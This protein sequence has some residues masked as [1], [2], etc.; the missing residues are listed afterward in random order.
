MSGRKQ[1]RECVLERWN[2][3]DW[4]PVKRR[5]IAFETHGQLI[6]DAVSA[7]APKLTPS[8][9]HFIGDG[10]KPYVSVEFIEATD[11]DAHQVKIMLQPRDRA[12]VSAMLLTHLRSGIGGGFTT[13]AV[14][15]DKRK[16]HALKTVAS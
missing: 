9:T 14:F 7:L 15:L 11:D 6:A 4:K 5:A 8:I 1:T 16:L 10:R 3:D 12:S 2:G 13:A